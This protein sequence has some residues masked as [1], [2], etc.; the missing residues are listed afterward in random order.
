MSAKMNLKMS[1]KMTT[2]DGVNDPIINPSYISFLIGLKFSYKSVPKSF[3]LD[4]N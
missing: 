1:A 3:L 4:K 2:L